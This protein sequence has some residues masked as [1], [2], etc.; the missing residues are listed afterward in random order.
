M[1]KIYFSFILLL[2]IY[3]IITSLL[4]FFQRNLLYHPNENNY[5]GDELKVPIKKI[6]IDTKDNLELLSL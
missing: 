4:Y 1:N 2:I 5:Y 3:L 6:K